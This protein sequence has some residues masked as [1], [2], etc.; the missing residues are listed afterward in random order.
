M[1]DSSSNLEGEKG[2]EGDQKQQQQPKKQQQ[3]Q[4]YFALKDWISFESCTTSGSNYSQGGMML[5]ALTGAGMPRFPEPHTLRF[6]NCVLK[7]SLMQFPVGTKF[8]EIAFNE[9]NVMYFYIRDASRQHALSRCGFEYL[10]HW[11][12]RLEF[13]FDGKKQVE[14]AE[15]VYNL[16]YYDGNTSVSQ[17]GFEFDECKAARDLGSL[18][19]GTAFASALLDLSNGAFSVTT[20]NEGAFGGRLLVRFCLKAREIAFDFLDQAFAEGMIDESD[21]KER[22][23]RQQEEQK[24][25]GGSKTGV[26]MPEKLPMAGEEIKEKTEK[27]RK[28]K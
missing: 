17:K 14:D 11:S 16:W 3:K 8:D 4:H 18:K 9:N 10:G 13:D 25:E 7:Q 24:R 28:I 22:K 12:I 20:D 15:N 26:D 23:R 1:T 21:L 6:R 2:K 19:K 5:L 27:K